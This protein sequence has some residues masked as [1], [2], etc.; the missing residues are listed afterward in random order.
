[1]ILGRVVGPLVDHLDLRL[2]VV[3]MD[4]VVSVYLVVLRQYLFSLGLISYL[5]VAFFPDQEDEQIP[6]HHMDS[7]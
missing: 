1:M 5:A 6:I 3:D 7:L 2:E 4:L